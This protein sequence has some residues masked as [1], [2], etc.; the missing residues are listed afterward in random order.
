MA[1]IKSGILGGM[2]GTIGDV[3]GYRRDGNDIIQSKPIHTERTLSE[4]MQWRNNINE[5]LLSLYSNAPT[6]TKTRDFT[7]TNSTTSMLERFKILQRDWPSLK[8]SSL[9][10][11]PIFG[12]TFNPVNGRY[13]TLIAPNGKNIEVE[14]SS[15]EVPAILVGSFQ[16]RLAAIRLNDNARVYT[17]ANVQSR[18]GILSIIRADNF[19]PEHVWL[20]QVA[21]H[22]P[23]VANPVSLLSHPLRIL[24]GSDSPYAEW[25]EY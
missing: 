18:N 25:F 7:N 22:R 9:F 1:K 2:S 24:V 3:T 6:E 21:V 11:N 17:N 5:S 19:E 16:H 4:A 14:W 8:K 23:N 10:R 13:R 20:I 15:L 12:Q